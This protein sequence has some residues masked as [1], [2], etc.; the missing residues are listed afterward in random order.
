MII[1]RK[2]SP[3][4]YARV[5]EINE[6]AFGQPAE[7]DLVDNLRKTEHAQLSLVAEVDGRLVGQVFFTLVTLE[8]GE[9][10]SPAL[11]LGP[12]AVLPEYQG[13]GVGSQ[14]VRVGLEECRRAGHLVVFVLGHPG[15]YPRFGFQPA[16]PKGITC[17][18]EVPEDVFMVAELAPGALGGRRGLVRYAPAFGQV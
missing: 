2:E 7:A 8:S 12:M 3:E 13:R 4:D 11:A 16:P 1:V 15:Y 9:E 10:A 5:R 17:Q 14:L 6:H 18:W